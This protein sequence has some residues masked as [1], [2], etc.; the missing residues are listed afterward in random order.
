[1]QHW[2]RTIFEDALWENRTLTRETKN[3]LDRILRLIETSDVHPFRTDQLEAISNDLSECVDL[4]E[5]S[6]LMWH[7]ATSVGFQN[8]TIFL[9][10]QGSA[11][12]FRSRVSTSYNEEWIARFQEKSYQYIDP[13]V[14]RA[15]TTDG[16]FLFSD[17]DDSSPIVQEF[18]RDAVNHRIGRNGLCFVFTRRDGA[19]IGISYATMNTAE[20][21]ADIVRFDGYDLQFL[22]QMAVDCFC[23][24]SCGPSLSDDTLSTEELRFL[25]ILSS[26]SNPEDALKVSLQF[27][28]NKTLQASIRTKLNVDSVYQAIAIAASKGWFNHLPYDPGEVSKPFRALEG[29]GLNSPK[30]DVEEPIR[31]IAEDRAVF[32]GKEPFE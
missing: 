5:L 12:T 20:K 19:R 25:H 4:T 21:V 8:Y 15:K 30:L 16:W 31:H 22:S 18:W 29:L 9:L 26:S 32:D 10:D 1:M 17:I 7:L 14:A 6:E 11:G 24:A 28:S 13:V 27:G 23:F 3:G 2:A